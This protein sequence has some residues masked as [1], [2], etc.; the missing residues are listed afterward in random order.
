MQNSQELIERFN[1]D[2][3]KLDFGKT[4]KN[5]YDPIY[6]SINVGGKRI[7][8]LLCLMANE[9]FEGKYEDVINAA[10]GIEIF[11]NFTLLHD[12]MMDKALVRRNK[13]VVHVKWNENIAL[14][15]GDAM[16]VIAYK[17]ICKSKNNL[18]DILDVF[19][20]TALEI[21]EGQ[22]YDMN[23]ETT[24]NVSE[25]QYLKMI[26]LKTAVLLAASLKIGAIC[27]NTTKNNIENI[28]DFGENLGLA[29]QLQDDLLD[30]FGNP[31]IFGKKIGGDILAN[32]KTYLLI[33][34][35]ELANKEQQKDLNYW[36][37]NKNSKPTEKIKSVTKIYKELNVHK[38]SKD[39][40]NKYFKTAFKSFEKL[41]VASSKKQV[42]YNYALSLKQRD[43]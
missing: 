28:Y 27:S 17:Y 26:R 31:K 22:Q 6:Y 32:K 39:L 12:D 43:S 2:L 29:F 41:E 9:L 40:M 11:H 36:I 42:L 21:C 13:P 5:L 14:L 34:A 18:R 37:S 1:Q 24:S 16:S 20:T 35:L 38:H 8:P 4:P 15:S 7:R 25:A 19:S 10:L 33:K 3:S 23:F 30:T